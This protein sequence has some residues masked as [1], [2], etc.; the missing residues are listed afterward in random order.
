MGIF[1]LIV[2]CIAFVL[3]CLSLVLTTMLIQNK[4][5]SKTQPNIT[6]NND[7]PKDNK[8]SED[9][10]N[11]WTNAI[12]FMLMNINITMFDLYRTNDVLDYETNLESFHTRMNHLAQNEKY[13]NEAVKEYEEYMKGDK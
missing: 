11:G 8:P 5:N 4:L 13:R 7:I 3:A 1:A 10:D 2:S 12:E 9:Y 6:V